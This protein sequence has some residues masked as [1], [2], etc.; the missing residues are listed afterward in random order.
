MEKLNGRPIHFVIR[1]TDLEKTLTFLKK[2]FGMKVLRHEENYSPCEISC[3]GPYQNAW[4]KTMI[5]YEKEDVAYCLEVTF[6]Y[7]TF[8]GEVTYTQDDSIQF[9]AIGGSD[10][11][12]TLTIANTLG[13]EVKEGVI[14]GPDGYKYKPLSKPT[15][16]VE[17]FL[18][19]RLRVSSIEVTTDFY[20]NV[21]GMQIIKNYT[22]LGEIRKDMKSVCVSFDSSHCLFEYVEDPSKGPITV[23]S[24]W[25]GRNALGVKDVGTVYEKFKAK[26]G[27]LHHEKRA[28]R[29]GMEIF[30]A[31]DFD[32]YEI[33]II[34]HD[35]FCK[36]AVRSTN[37]K[38]P[39]YEKRKIFLDTYDWPFPQEAEII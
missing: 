3:N 27:T 39:D 17:P 37:H 21:I 25:Q 38:E 36:D 35:E 16:R 18:G 15:D 34:T 32:G 13:Y 30:I 26:N 7:P 10:R 23:A 24:G 4:S 5:G 11:D 8:E 22:S 6:N 9:I 12:G 28:L 29:E 19:V 14:V 20:T 31:K 33:C 1:T 2:V